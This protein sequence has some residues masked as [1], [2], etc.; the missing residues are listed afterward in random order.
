MVGAVTEEEMVEPGG[1]VLVAG[2]VTLGWVSSNRIKA[3]ESRGSWRGGL[4][5]DW[6]RMNWSW[7]RM[8]PD[9]QAPS[10]VCTVPAGAGR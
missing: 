7:I 3:V 10:V 1:W 2:M 4:V 8:E 6:M 9:R 5:G